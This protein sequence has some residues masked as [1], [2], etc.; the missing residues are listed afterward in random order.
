M[1][2]SSAPRRIE[3]LLGAFGAESEFAEG[4]IG[5]LAEEYAIREQWDGR[6]VARR[7]YY[8]EALRVA[9]HLLRSW[10]RGLRW[11]DVGALAESAALASICA[12]TLSYILLW[13]L[14]S[15][16]LALGFRP[17]RTTTAGPLLLGVAVV[18][19][20]SMGSF[21]GYVA[22]RLHARAPVPGAL[23][24]AGFW[25]ILMIVFNVLGG[26]AT[27]VVVPVW[28]RLASAGTIV[29]GM[30]VGGI[31]RAWQASRGQDEKTLK[32]SP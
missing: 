22:A 1:S 7:W 28:M 25:G 19:N 23:S 21:A 2:E 9:P 6:A 14:G 13:S 10:I 18:W 24:L 32:P 20:F 4:V 31:L 29:C 26:S 12:I 8:R 17:G 15:I 16:G 30:T 27:S 5:D 3:R 11:G